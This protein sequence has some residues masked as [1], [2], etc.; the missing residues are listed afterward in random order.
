I[1]FLSRKKKKIMQDLDKIKSIEGFEKIAIEN[2]ALN[3]LPRELEI[4]NV[5]LKFKESEHYKRRD[6]L[7]KKVKKLKKAKGILTI[8]LKDTELK[9]EENTKEKIINK[10]TPVSPVWKSAIK[11][12]IE[13]KSTGK[14]YKILNLEKYTIG[15]GESAQGNDQLRKEWATKNDI[16]FH[17]DGDK[18]SHI[19]VKLKNSVLDMDLL[20]VIAQIMIESSKLDYTEANLVYTAVKNL[21]GVKGVPGKVIYKKEKRVKVECDKNY[22]DYLIN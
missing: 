20:A 11:K 19:I 14:K 2:N 13:V 3:E 12:A 7:Y 17:L 21:K 10:L 6:E 4:N 1:K 8:R 22:K 15:V 18:S 5:K 16:W 9:L